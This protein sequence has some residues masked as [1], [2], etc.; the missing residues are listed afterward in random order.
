MPLRTNTFKLAEVALSVALL[1]VLLSCSDGNRAAPP[2]ATPAASTTTAAPDTTNTVPVSAS[3]SLGPPET[4]Y[5][6]TTSTSTSTTTS[7]TTTST[8][9]TTPERVVEVSV[10]WEDIDALLS[11][12]ERAPRWSTVLRYGSGPDELGVLRPIGDDGAT[13]GPA[14]LGLF[15]DR[16]AICDQVNGRWLLIDPADGTRTFAIE[17]G[18]PAVAATRSGIGWWAPL[19]GT[20][21]LGLDLGTGERVDPVT[22]DREVY[23]MTAMPAGLLLGTTDGDI[24]IEVLPNPEASSG[25]IVDFA[26]D[27]RRLRLDN[28]DGSATVWSFDDT[29][30]WTPLSVQPITTD[31]VAIVLYTPDLQNYVAARLTPN[32]VAGAYQLSATQ[33]YEGFG[34]NTIGLD[35]TGLAVLSTETSGTSVRLQVYDLP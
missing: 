35:Q 24:T 30:R 14:G 17:A 13:I 11:T 1:I 10:G 27:P 33:D 7:T 31:E 23:S 16:V 12:T 19:G 20:E 3:T 18:G 21:I 2:V 34:T 8:T 4:S 26:V 15:G 28:P 9:S 32:G 29:V 6:P 25:R 5:A 22:S